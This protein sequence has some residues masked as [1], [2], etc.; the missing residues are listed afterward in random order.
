MNLL[1]NVEATLV[2]CCELE[3]RSIDVSK[4]LGIWRRDFSVVNTTFIV[5]CELNLL[6]NV[7][8]TLEKVCNFEVVASTSL[9]RHVLFVRCCTAKVQ[10]C[11]NVVTMLYACWDSSLKNELQSAFQ[12]ALIIVN[13]FQ[14]RRLKRTLKS[15]IPFINLWSHLPSRH[16]SIPALQIKFGLAAKI[17]SVQAEDSLAKC[18]G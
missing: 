13:F 8:T 15:I 11:Y 18:V 17:R 4:T 16:I 5:H 7:E 12:S 10:C 6:S 2:Q 3:H 9:R 14:I 1:F